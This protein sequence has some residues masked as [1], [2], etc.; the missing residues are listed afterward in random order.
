M[1]IEEKGWKDIEEEYVQAKREK[2]SLPGGTGRW[3]KCSRCQGTGKA[4]C[5]SCKGLGRNLASMRRNE[6]CPICQGTGK[7]GC[8]QPGCQGGWVKVNAS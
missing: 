7:A 4:T 3:G 8:P 2:Q 5:P 1:P 6:A